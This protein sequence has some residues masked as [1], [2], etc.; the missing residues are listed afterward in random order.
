M[1]KLPKRRDAILLPLC[2]TN[3]QLQ[4]YSSSLV[5]LDRHGMQAVSTVLESTA[6]ARA[7]A[8]CVSLGCEEKTERKVVPIAK[9]FPQ[10]GRGTRLLGTSGSPRK[11]E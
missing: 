3:H 4:E 2:L 8:G 5:R 1:L 7:L 10:W 6:E 9:F 11:T